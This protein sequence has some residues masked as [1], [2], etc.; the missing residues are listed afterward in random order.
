MVTCRE[1]W[2]LWWIFDVILM[3]KMVNISVWCITVEM[4]DRV[5]C[6]QD[7]YVIVQRTTVIILERLERVLGMEVSHCHLK[8][9]SREFSNMCVTV[10]VTFIVLFVSVLPAAAIVSMCGKIKIDSYDC[11][12]W[13][14]LLS[15]FFFFSKPTI[16]HF[17]H[18]YDLHE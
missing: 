7:C 11:F 12:A 15:F 8:P 5:V 18:F 4:S 3:V 10:A 13:Y 1:Y 14:L 6:F 17:S 9:L 2:W 16:H